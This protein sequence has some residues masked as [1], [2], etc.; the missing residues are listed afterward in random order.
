LRFLRPLTGRLRARVAWFN[1]FARAIGLVS[2]VRRPVRFLAT[3]L[4]RADGRP[5]VWTLR[6][7]PGRVALRSGSRD[8]DIFEEIFRDDEYEP[9]PEALAA[10]EREGGPRLIADLGGNVGL[11]GLFALRRFPSARV[12]SYEPDPDNLPLLRRCHEEWVE[13]D[14]WELREV[15]A[16]NEPGALPFVSGMQAESRRPVFSERD[17]D[18]L[19]EV[20]M[21]DVLPDLADAD[22]I[23]IDI[24]GGEWPILQDERFAGTKARALVLEYH[25][26]YKPK[27]DASAAAHEL[28]RAAGFETRE[29][30]TDPRPI[31]LGVIWA[32][33]ENA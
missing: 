22:L 18:D 8:V 25:G 24:E 23:K 6:D 27:P 11:F 14:R 17:R 2:L 29:V 13:R 32:W 20:P 19:I 5:R 16:G 1:R 31:Q 4:L 30:F 21:V 9:P 33:R 26:Q 15:A 12:V 7:A 3:E 28:L 10:L